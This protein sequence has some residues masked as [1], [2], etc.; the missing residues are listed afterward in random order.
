VRKADKL[1]T[2][3]CRHVIWEPL[4]SWNP[5][6]HP[7]PVTGLLYLYF[8]TLSN[9]MIGL[10]EFRKTKKL[11]KSEVNITNIK[12]ELPTSRNFLK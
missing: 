9:V 4:N 11:P 6:G 8:A 3:L 12:T 5:L 10:N 7:R 1:T 2:I